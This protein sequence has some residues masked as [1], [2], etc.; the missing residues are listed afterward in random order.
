[1]KKI[2]TH[3]KAGDK[4]QVIAGNHKNE[5]GTILQILPKKSQV[6][7][8]GVHMIKKHVK[9]TQEQPEGGIVEKEGPIHISNV[10]LLD[11]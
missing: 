8:E 6:I 2:K 9:P 1:M 4:V 7:I 10:K 5:T 3:V 11:K